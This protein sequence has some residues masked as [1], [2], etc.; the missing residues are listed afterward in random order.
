MLTVSPSSPA[1][2]WPDGMSGGGVSF[3]VT[4]VHGFLTS[5]SA[6]GNENRAELF[7]LNVPTGLLTAMCHR[8]LRC[9]MPGTTSMSAFMIQNLR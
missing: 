8:R 6:R 3:S 9:R 4:M 1:G 5:A 7:D 2:G